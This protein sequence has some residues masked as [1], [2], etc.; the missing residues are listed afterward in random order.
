MTAASAV[1]FLNPQAEV[2]RR[3]LALHAN[4]NAAGGLEDI[5]RSN[6]G[7][8]GT[9]KLLVSGSG[10][11]R[12]SKD[13]AVLLQNMEIVNPTAKLI[14]RTATAQDDEQGDGTTT[15]VLL[16]GELLRQAE[17]Y[18]VDGVHP[19]HLVDGVEAAREQLLQT[20]VPRVAIPLGDGGGVARE[21]L[22]RVARTALGTKLND[23]ALL[24]HYADMVVD[25]VRAVQR[26]AE[27]IDL[28]MVEV[29]SME[30]RSAMDSRLVRGLV[31]D[32]GTRHPDMPKQLRN[33]RVL[34]CNVSLEY[35][36]PEVNSGFYYADA[37]QRE[38]LAQAERAVIAR[39]V[40]KIVALRRR[41]S[42]A[43]DEASLLVINQKGIAP[44]ALDLLAREGVMAL[45]RAK[46]RNMERLVLACGGR[47]VNSL[48]D[49]T[50]EVLGY[51]ER[52][53]EETLGED[54]FTYVEGVSD[55]RS[56]TLL[57]RGPNKHTIH[58]L[59]DAVRDGLR[60]VKNALE[61]RRALPGAGA[62]E[63]GAH[64]HLREHAKQVAGRARL[65]VQLFADALLIVPKTLAESA[66]G[67]M[68]TQ[69]TVLRLVQAHE[70]GERV[71]LN[72]NTGEPMDA[73]EQG[74]LDG[75][76]AKRQALG[77]ATMIA[78]QLLLVDELLR[79]GRDT[80]SK[81]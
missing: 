63:C 49:L 2:S 10:E 65:G 42:A 69:D 39:N 11:L 50:P 32:H 5:L 38:R 22:V 75:Y 35:E 61:E 30:S 66:G 21:P 67:G 48:D 17:R 53:Y 81:R 16:T 14:A 74:V 44:E 1:K 64:V 8:R 40:E 3:G 58:Q 18:L 15:V 47:A 26:G 25:A 43:G 77:L 72:V 60:A 76:G 36:K 24:H 51:A 71:G 28:F 29:M 55:G 4:I 31:L 56:C 6:L 7:P 54:K 45:R 19:R 78:S 37:Q 9:L 79:A 57:V 12:L 33:A 59:K 73:V 80:R 27:P 52:V 70:R 13:G 34:I 41:V 62:F 20:Y 23:A 46:R 68:D